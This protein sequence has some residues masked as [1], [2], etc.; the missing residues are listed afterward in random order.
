MCTMQ[1]FPLSCTQKNSPTERKSSQ[2][3]LTCLGIKIILKILGSM[4]WLSWL[5]RC[6]HHNDIVYG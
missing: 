1:Y 4:F 3:M 6:G 5:L 2:M